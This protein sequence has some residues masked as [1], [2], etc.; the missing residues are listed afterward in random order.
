[1][2]L[3]LFTPHFYHAFDDGFEKQPIEVN[4][5]FISKN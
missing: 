3:F 2:S 5:W 4:D 1:M